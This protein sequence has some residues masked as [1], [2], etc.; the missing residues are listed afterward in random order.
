MTAPSIKVLIV[1]GYG[2]FGGRLA[3][4]LAVET[5]VSLLVAGRSIEKARA[6][7]DTYL[8]GADAQPVV[9]DR[10]GDLVPALTA[11]APDLVVDASGPFQD[12]QGDVYRLVRA[13]LD[14]GCDYVDLADATAFVIGIVQ[15]G[16][17][18][19]END[20]FV[21]S[22]AS[23]YPALSSAAVRRL[24]DPMAHVERITAGIAPSPYAKLGVNVVRAGIGYGGK[25][26][27]LVYGGKP[28]TG[29]ALAESRRS[30]V[31]PP[32]RLP[33][34]NRRFSLVDV[35][36]LQ[37]LPDLWP[38][39]KAVWLGF[40]PGP[41]LP[42]H[43]FNLA[44]SL[45]RFRVLPSLRPFAPIIAWLA[46]WMR[47]GEDRSGMF[48]AVAGRDAD[49]RRIERSWHLVAED[50]DG[51]FIPAMAVAAIVRRC[52]SGRRPE[53]GARP[54][55]GDVDLDDYEHLFARHAIQ[56]GTRESL[57]VHVDMP[58]YRRL[59]G[60]AWSDL[61]APIQALHDLAETMVAEGQAEVR[62][63]R[64]VLSRLAG[65]A[66]GFPPAGDNVRVRV[67]FTAENGSETWK[68]SFG[69]RTFQS[70]QAQGRG[71]SAYLLNERFGP[72]TVGLALVVKDECLHLVVRRWTLFG[73]AMPLGLAPTSRSFESVEHG[74]FCFNV[75]IGHPL[76]G[77]I[78]AYR[79]W[80]E[81][82]PLSGVE[83][84]EVARRKTLFHRSST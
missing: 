22:G 54:A 1:G 78:V 34:R 84:A 41:D 7:C 49:G 28:L 45:V 68:R 2:T 53:S 59:L 14:T 32:G 38:G 73:L 75:E 26:V 82:R 76:T 31:A 27:T 71:R 11:L 20:C 80:L 65:M 79:G 62:R 58:L 16:R 56:S 60:T 77:R 67:V 61:P 70:I 52:L 63:G 4:L 44:A 15:F 12:Y 83:A 36:D 18:A 37:L 42:Q 69:G 9:F 3:R 19:R 30:T 50:D 39:L 8:T 17:E 46:S 23:S 55:T 24:A 64:S 57:P 66:F 40:S 81:P 25:P 43:G 21:I 10:D 74:R 29:Y 35:P 51:P 33:L 6:F 72:V 47:W 48:V 13:C 5:G